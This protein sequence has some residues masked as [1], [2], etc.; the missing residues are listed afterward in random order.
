MKTIKIDNEALNRMKFEGQDFYVIFTAGWCGYCAALKREINAADAAF[1]LFEFDISD[2]E[3]PAWEDYD[4][5][6]VPTALYFKSGKEQS[7]KAASLAGLS[8]K[9]IK[10]LSSLP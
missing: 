9:D 7:R 1:E 10:A 5:Q 2:E 8:V 4:I 3:C 6:V